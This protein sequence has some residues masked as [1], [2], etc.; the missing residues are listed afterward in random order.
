[1]LH[2]KS[3]RLIACMS[4]GPEATIWWRHCNRTD[5][6]NLLQAFPLQPDL[7][8]TRSEMSY[9]AVQS[10][11][12][13]RCT[14]LV[15]L[16]VLGA[17][18]QQDVSSEVSIAR[19]TELTLTEVFRIGDETAGD[20]VL[21][22]G[23]L[24]VGVNSSGQLFVTDDGIAGIRVF[25]D[26]GVLMQMIGRAGEG[27][28][29]FESTPMVHV[30][31]R[32]TVYALDTIADRLTVFAPDNFSPV[33]TIDISGS[34]T[35]DAESE[36]Y[37][38][39]QNLI[40][41]VRDGFL[42]QYDGI[43]APL[44]SA[45]D[46]TELTVLKLLNR[47]GEVSADTMVQMRSRDMFHVRTGARSYVAGRLPFGRDAF[48]K[49]SPDKLLYYGR[50]DPIEIQ[51]QSIDGNTRRIV[52]VPHDP[53]PVTEDER[54]SWLSDLPD[55]AQH[56]L[57]SVFPRTRPAYEAFL[58]DD[59]ERIWLRLSAPKDSQEA[60]WIVVS[61]EGRIQATTTLPSSVWLKVIADNRAIGTSSD[62][63][64]GA[65]LVVAYEIT[66]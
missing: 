28:G 54:N 22:G 21:F 2:R 46:E 43:K 14:L 30:G 1:M 11:N 10:T 38:S 41:T 47:K 37:Q 3:L 6:R 56:E 32:D 40:G 27:P 35:F 45:I 64:E 25:S 48:I 49:V 60:R 7:N 26:T 4:R 5:L 57:R 16:L 61:L 53:V 36:S 23:D 55:N 66:E 13:T 31:P 34:E 39:A 63:D 44:L 52:R 9:F 8:T 24:E 33:E 29:E 42:V 58:L 50:N 51:V 17:C 12:L 59:S 65:P 19:A 18:Q 15:S 20:T 62:E